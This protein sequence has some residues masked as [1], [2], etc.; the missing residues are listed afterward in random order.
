MTW[1]IIWFDARGF[2]VDLIDPPYIMPVWQSLTGAMTPEYTFVTERTPLKDGQQLKYIDVENREVD[3]IVLVRGNSEEDL[4]NR[5]NYL[6][7][8]FNPRQ[9]QGRLRVQTPT[10]VTRDLVCYPSSGFR[11][12]ESSMTRTSVELHLT[13]LTIGPPYWRSISQTV[14]SFKLDNPPTFFPLPP[15]TLGGEAI[16]SV[17]ELDNFGHV[18][19]QPVWKITGPGSDPK[20]TNQTTGEYIAL[21]NNGGITL[22]AGQFI[23]IDTAQKTVTLN[24]GTNLMSRVDW[25]STFFEIPNNG[26]FAEGT[27]IKVEMTGATDESSI[28]VRY[29]TYFLGVG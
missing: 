19:T 22:D 8:F 16:V 28:E 13:F 12:S 23:V 4:W 21:T 3:L 9:G 10:G 27:S 7:N 2:M 15:I 1:S 25:E 20:I 29:Y 11:L 24:D 6:S 5:L 18:S 17:F 26:V 14:K